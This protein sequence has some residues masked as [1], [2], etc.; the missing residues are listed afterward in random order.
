[1][2]TFTIKKDTDFCMKG[3]KK[4]FEKKRKFLPVSLKSDNLILTLIAITI[5]L[6]LQ[7]LW[8]IQHL[9][10]IHINAID[11]HPVKH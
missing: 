7:E 1:M 9:F 8:K 4:Q 10:I 6:S 3:R 11:L 2:K 5:V